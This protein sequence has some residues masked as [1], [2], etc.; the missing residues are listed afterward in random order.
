VAQDAKD[1]AFVARD[2]KVGSVFLPLQP[3]PREVGAENGPVDFAEGVRGT[4]LRREGWRKERPL[5][6]L[7]E[8]EQ[9]H[10]HSSWEENWARGHRPQ[11]PSWQ[12]H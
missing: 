6:Q 1:L 9:V 5:R 12:G 7:E 2:A 4:M 11:G 3:Q 10:Q 8:V